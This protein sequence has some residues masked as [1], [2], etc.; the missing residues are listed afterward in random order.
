MSDLNKLDAAIKE[1]ADARLALWA[2]QKGLKDTEENLKEA[3]ERMEEAEKAMTDELRANPNSPDARR[4]CAN[5]G[6]LMALV[7]SVEEKIQET[8]KKL[9]DAEKRDAKSPVKYREARR[10]MKST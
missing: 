9:V 3:A 5:Y 10:N 7:I 6:G 4:A 1:I 8:K 2:T